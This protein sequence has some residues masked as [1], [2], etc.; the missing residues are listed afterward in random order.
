MG[1]AKKIAAS[2]KR[3]VKAFHRLDRETIARIYIHGSGIEIGALHC[4]LLLPKT[5]RVK[6]VDRLPIE[7]LREKYKDVD[8]ASIIPVDILDNGEKLEKFADASQDFVEEEAEQNAEQS[9]HDDWGSIFTCGVKWKCSI[10]SMLSTGSS[11]NSMWS[12][13]SSAIRKRFSLSGRRWNRH[14]NDHQST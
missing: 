3:F 10:W 6:Y 11:L 8:P 13:S 12:S 7:G 9:L 1:Q 5:A 4:P 14:S 2:F